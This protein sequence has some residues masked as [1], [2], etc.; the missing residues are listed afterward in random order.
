MSPIPGYL[1]PAAEARKVY[2]HAG[3]PSNGTSAVQHVDL[4]GT[5]TGGT[6]KLRYKGQTTAAIAYNATTG[7]MQTALR[8]LGFIGS[9]GVTVTGSAGAW[10]VTFGGRLAKLNVPTL[11]VADNSLTGG[12]DPD[13]AVTVATPGVTATA[14]G[15]QPGALLRDTTN[16]T[17]YIN[18]G[19]IYAPAWT[20]QDSPSAE[21][22]SFEAA[23][24]ASAITA[25]TYAAVTGA[26]GANDTLQGNAG[27]QTVPLFLNLADVAAGDLLTNY[28]PGFA[29]RVL[30]VDFA[31]HKPVTTAS[32][33]A[34]LNLEVGTTNLSG[35]VVALTSANATHAGALIAGTA[36]SGSNAFAANDTLSVEASAVTGFSEGSGWLLLTLSNDETLNNFADVAAKIDAILTLLNTTGIMA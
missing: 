21:M 1:N 11:A 6:F 13:I 7:A 23:I 15:A 9:D 26:A 35:G 27:R 31:V 29:G 22:A 33:A 36:V 2:A 12:T 16:G 4:S 18:A 30:A 25:L 20:L 24:P 14:R 10:V 3:V 17:E 5:P 8:A 32:K 28:T 34:S 19:T